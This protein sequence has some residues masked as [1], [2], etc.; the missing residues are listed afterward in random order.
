MLDLARPGINC[1]FALVFE[2]LWVHG[3]SDLVVTPSVFVRTV[4]FW[5]GSKTG[6]PLL[7][8]EEVV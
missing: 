4:V 1:F 3:P 7:W 8:V 2:S 6:G 5:A